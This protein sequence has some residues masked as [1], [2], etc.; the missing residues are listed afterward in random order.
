ML[1]HE[2]GAPAPAAPTLDLVRYVARQFPFVTVGGVTHALRV[3]PQ[4][5]SSVVRTELGTTPKSYITRARLEAAKC[6]LGQSG[7]TAV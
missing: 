6:L 7:E 3:S 5:L 1:R 2:P 4:R